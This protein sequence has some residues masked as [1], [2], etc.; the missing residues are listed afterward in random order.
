[1]R[2]AGTRTPKA[3]AR[4]ARRWAGEVSTCMSE[5]CKP[6]TPIPSSASSIGAGVP[7][8]LRTVEIML[9]CAVPDRP[10]ALAELAG[11][12]AEAGGDIEAVDVVDVD[13]GVALDDLV[14][15]LSDPGHLRRLMGRLDALAD[16]RIV[17]VAPSRGHPSDAVTRLAVGL[18]AVL[19]G[20]MDA[21]HGLQAL[22]G[23]LLRADS[24][25]VVEAGTE[26]D[27]AGGVAVAPLGGRR[28][29]VR[30]GYP[31]TRTERDRFRA[32]VRVCLEAAE[33]QPRR[34]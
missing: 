7:R 32:I 21:E 3:S 34:A 23:G 4:G 16:V 10:G 33:R 31:F 26:P 20:A 24:L 9:R 28:V 25:V 17:H 15:V 11:V 12:I 29:V 14:V 6:R 2:A 18:E 30:R 5:I 1:M 13:D 22:A 8:S 27:E 19:S